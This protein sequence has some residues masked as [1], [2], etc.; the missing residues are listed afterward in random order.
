MEDLPDGY[1]RLPHRPP[2]TLAPRPHPLGNAGDIPSGDNREPGIGVALAQFGLLHMV[3]R[4]SAAA[5]TRSNPLV[6]ENFGSPTPVY[7][8]T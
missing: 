1:S 7:F 4:L 2:R 5:R 3:R 8:N 6:C